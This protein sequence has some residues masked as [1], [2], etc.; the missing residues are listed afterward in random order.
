ME[1]FIKANLERPY[2]TEYGLL[3][4]EKKVEHRGGITMWYCFSCDTPMT[5]QIGGYCALCGGHCGQTQLTVNQLQ[6]RSI[7]S[8][9]EFIKIGHEEID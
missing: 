7:R 5:E 2:T 9:K 8:K 1:E 3:G 4:N 6:Q